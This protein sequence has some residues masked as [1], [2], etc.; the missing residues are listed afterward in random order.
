MFSRGEDGSGIFASAVKALGVLE[1][2]A[3]PTLERYGIFVDPEHE[4][5]FAG[6]TV[7][8]IIKAH[9]WTDAVVDFVFWVLVW[10]Y[11]N[12]L[13]HYGTVWREWGLRD[14]VVGREPRA[15]ARHIAGHLDDTIRMKDDPGRYGTGGLD[16]LAKDIPQPHE[17][18][19]AAFFD[20]LQRLSSDTRSD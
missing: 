8:A 7:R 13:D 10:N 15:F 14:A 16:K 2:A 12:T 4:Y 11:Y 17:P 3:L 18:W 5:Y 1:S 9:G 19:A 6:T 20:E